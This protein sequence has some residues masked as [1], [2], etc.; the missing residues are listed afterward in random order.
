MDKTNLLSIRHHDSPPAV[1]VDR[2]IGLLKLL[3]EPRPCC[4][5]F[6]QDKPPGEDNDVLLAVIGGG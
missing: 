6:D 5:A 2:R 1:S 3:E 4:S